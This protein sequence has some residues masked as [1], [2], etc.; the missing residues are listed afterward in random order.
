LS[1]T[2]TPEQRLSERRPLRSRKVMR[3]LGLLCL[4]SVLAL[5]LMY[6]VYHTQV[7]IAIVD[8]VPSWLW[9]WLYAALGFRRRDGESAEDGVAV[10]ILLLC[11]VVA[12]GAVGVTYAILKRVGLKRAG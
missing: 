9:N 8:S 12:A 7:G 3:W 4:T 2:T 5:A 1:E 10:V 6:F 11:T